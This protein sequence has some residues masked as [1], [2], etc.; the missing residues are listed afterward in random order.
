[1]SQF[2]TRKLRRLESSVAEIADVG[3]CLELH[4]LSLEPRRKKWKSQDGYP[5]LAHDGL[6]L[7]EVA[8]P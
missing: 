3:S 8:F 1:M 6:R 7:L 5:T 4:S 2:R